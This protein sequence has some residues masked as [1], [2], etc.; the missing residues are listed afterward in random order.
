MSWRLNYTSHRSH[1]NATTEQVQ[2]L[3]LLKD[4][5]TTNII[6]YTKHARSLT[7]RVHQGAGHGFLSNE[8]LDAIGTLSTCR[9]D[10]VRIL[11]EHPHVSRKLAIQVTAIK[12]QP[13]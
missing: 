8:Q 2:A 4:E 6:A 12:S 9:E 11:L 1:I 7:H 5:S 3:S 13:N 10:E